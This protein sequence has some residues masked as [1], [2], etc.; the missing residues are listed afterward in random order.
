[1]ATE[2]LMMAAVRAGGRRQELHERIRVHSLDAARAMKEQ[3]GKNDLM[4]RLRGDANFAAVDLEAEVEP[5]RF[6]GRSREQVDE[7]LKT[8]VEPIR[9]K[10]SGGT[11]STT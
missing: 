6:V 9:R 10:I 2:N 4:E 11:G 1:M 7:F 8:Q 3:G 5:S